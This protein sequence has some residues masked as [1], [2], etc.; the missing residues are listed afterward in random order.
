ME[1]AAEALKPITAAE[2]VTGDLV[3]MPEESDENDA[4]NA[5][6]T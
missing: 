3:Q 6:E 2:V 4:H 5:D 1:H